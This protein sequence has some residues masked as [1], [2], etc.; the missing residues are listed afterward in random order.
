[1][2]Y[3]SSLKVYVSV[4]LLAVIACEARA[5]D[6][7]GLK[8][9]PCTIKLVDGTQIKGRLV[10]QLNMDKRLIV[11][12]PRLATFRS[13]LKRHVHVLSVDG[14]RE[15]LNPKGALSEADH[16]LLGRTTW[17][18][19]PPKQGRRPDYTQE[20]WNA[21]ERLLVWANP[22]TSGALHKEANWHIVGKPLD[23]SN[24]GGPWLSTDTDI[25]LPASQEKYRVKYGDRDAGKARC[26]HVTVEHK[27]KVEFSTVQAL[28]GNVWSARGGFYRSRYT[29]RLSGGK[30]TFFLNDRPLLTPEAPQAEPLGGG[31]HIPYKLPDPGW[32]DYRVAQYLRVRKAKGASAEFVGS[33]AS[34]DDFQLVSGT[35]IVGED[36]QLLPGARS[37]QLFRKGTTL[38]LMSGAEYGKRIN[39]WGSGYGI[40]Y[41]TG[42]T[43]AVIAGR[44]EAG[45]EQHPIT[46]DVRFGL[47]F[48]AVPGVRDLEHPQPSL[49]LG[50]GADI[51]VHTADPDQAKLVIDW[52]QRHHNWHI[53]RTE[54]YK[55]WPREIIIAIGGMPMLEN[56]RFN[57]LARDGLKLAFP[58]IVKQW[59]NVTFGDRCRGKPDELITHWPESLRKPFAS[60][61][62]YDQPQWRAAIS[63]SGG[64]YQGDESVKV[65]MDVE[66]EAAVEG[67]DVR[68][69]LDGSEPTHDSR[70]YR[71]P[72]V[73]DEEA[74][75]RARCFLGDQPMP[76]EPA[77]AKFVFLE[78]GNN[79]KP[80]LVYR[81]YEG[82]WE[83]LPKFS[84]LKPVD[85]GVVKQP[86]LSMTDRGHDFALVFTGFIT[87]PKTGEYTFYTESDDGSALYINGNKIVDNDGTHGS[88]EASG[89][90]TL[91][92]GPQMLRIT[93]FQAG[94]GKNLKVKWKRPGGEKQTIP[95]D[96]LK[97]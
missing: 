13:I 83:T 8:L 86:G 11:Y 73:V 81:L 52:H 24:T 54:G 41:G 90:V 18:S 21:P 58:S 70:L 37:A 10:T 19:Q 85:R 2:R 34:S 25:L 50:P 27:A 36:S 53:N 51:A 62:W 80:G 95:A 63:P 46:K 29:T 79:A 60:N 67:V 78:G 97:H 39:Q 76:G 9:E 14:R 56:V 23:Q 72:I 4:C 64:V 57:D 48:K 22:G 12:S 31:Y 33:V 82:E 35:A 96:V 30:D 69:T 84:Q 71:E 45:T 94:G 1:M 61:D 7:P 66:S 65:R 20:D 3:S 38:R 74:T 59:K 77:E 17:P 42:S 44:I 75:V 91:N 43:D 93:Y 68:Y 28:T 15:Q 47:S 55:D 16:H 87:V 40:R 49:V 88:Q 32:N 92:K 5:Q 6:A 26:R 89:T